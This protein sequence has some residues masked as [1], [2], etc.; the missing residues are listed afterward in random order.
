MQNPSEG[1]ESKTK[2]NVVKALLIYVI[3]LVIFYGVWIL[4]KV[5]YEQI[6]TTLE[7]TKEWY[8]YPTLAGGLSIVI[9][10]SI[11]GWWRGSL[12][13]KVKSKAKYVWIIPILM[14]LISVITLSNI[15]FSDLPTGILLWS[16]LGGI[17]V[18][19]GEEMI[20][21]GSMIFGLR[22]KFPETK[23]WL[24]STLL[25]SA[26]HIPNVLFGLRPSGAIAQ[27]VFTFIIGSALYMVRRVSGNLILPMFLH[28]LWDS[29]T[30][31]AGAADATPAPGA[32]LIYPVSLVCLIVFLHGNKKLASTEQI[33]T[34]N[35]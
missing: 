16:I 27:L 11:F 19:F 21:R 22:S 24:I 31:L 12:F 7:N 15:T 32:A 18:G 14:T 3:Y 10:V 8:A 2:P 13:E 4:T 33:A 17:G 25:F 23:V 1:I 28:G 5:D 20:T 9:L 26:L 34:Q 30:F 29:S 6:G 35:Q